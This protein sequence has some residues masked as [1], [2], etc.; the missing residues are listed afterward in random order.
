MK[1]S[2][3]VVLSAVAG[4]ALASQ[5][6]RSESFTLFIYESKADLAARTDS[7]Q[8]AA[9]RAAYGE[10]A[11]Q[12]TEAGILRGGSALH[13]DLETR[14][15]AVLGGKPQVVAAKGVEGARQLGG[16]FVIEVA[17]AEVAVEW[18]KKA[19]FLSR[20]SVSVSRHFPNPGMSA[21]PTP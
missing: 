21:K 4:L 5:A 2:K 20:G 18:A 1:T 9:Y 8:A 13:G 10:F 19:P 6:V 15:V 3:F 17:N 14:T 11:K 7:T 16:Y 12:M